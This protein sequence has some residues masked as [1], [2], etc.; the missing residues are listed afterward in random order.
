[1]HCVWGKPMQPLPHCISPIGIK[2]EMRCS[3][4]RFPCNVQGDMKVSGNRFA[5]V[6][7]S[8]IALVGSFS[9]IQTLLFRPKMLTAYM[10]GDELLVTAEAQTLIT[11]GVII[12][13]CLVGALTIRRSGAGGKV[14]RAVLCTCPS[15]CSI[16]LIAATRNLVVPLAVAILLGVACSFQMQTL[17]TKR[18]FDRRSS[19]EDYALS[20]VISLCASSLLSHL[21]YVFSDIDAHGTLVLALIMTAAGALVAMLPATAAEPA[22]P[23]TAHETSKRTQVSAMARA[24]G[25]IVPAGVICSLSLGMSWNSEAFEP[26]LREPVLFALG[27]LL[28][29]SFLLLLRFRWKRRGEEHGTEITVFM[30]VPSV[31]GI[32]ATFLAG[33]LDISATFTILV[34]SNLSF[35]SLIW[36]EM[37]YLC[38]KK[39]FSSS[40][41]PV[42][43][44]LMIMVVFLFGMLLSS[45]L[46]PDIALVVAPIIALGYLVYLFFH[47][48]KPIDY[49]PRS[50]SPRLSFDEIRE[51]ACEQM[52][53]DFGL[54]AKEAEVLTQ[55]V[56]GISAPAIGKRLF[57]S[58][59]TVKTHK[60][61]IYQK[62]GV[63]NYEETI[64]VFGVYADAVCATDQ[65]VY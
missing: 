12:L 2:M 8:S 1:M 39:A 34:F 13:S 33:V 37:L 47:A 20:A 17:L 19:L 48:Q 22:E 46:P 26:V 32:L 61:H 63:H 59:E 18:P 28:A 50:K 40:A 15:L 31:A 42:L 43:S 9:Y 23:A 44:I 51:A 27:V 41:I 64:E 53:V 3:S 30:I 7:L 52:A 6:A 25:P 56:T 57:I 45:I 36:I 49:R 21:G 62:M 54:S 60:Y 14:I 58:H 4:W 16:V 5:S 65:P 11:V 35:L 29:A 24:V 38:G 10:S 55:L